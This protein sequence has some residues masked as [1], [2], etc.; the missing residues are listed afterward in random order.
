MIRSCALC[1]ERDDL[2]KDSNKGNPHPFCGVFFS[3]RNIFVQVVTLF[4]Q[5]MFRASCFTYLTVFE[6]Q[7]TK[8]FYFYLSFEYVFFFFN[9]QGRTQSA[10]TL[11]FI[12]ITQPVAQV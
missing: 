9:L 11:V 5:F 12:A 4:Y 1:R 10:F 8:S 7:K 6:L 2:K 3:S